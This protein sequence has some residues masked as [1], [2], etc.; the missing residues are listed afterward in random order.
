M[1]QCHVSG[2]IKLELHSLIKSNKH[3]S[4]HGV[5]IP[6]E[7][8]RNSVSNNEKVLFPRISSTVPLPSHATN[9]TAHHQQKEQPTRKLKLGKGSNTLYEVR[10]PLQSQENWKCI[11]SKHQYQ[12]LVSFN[13]L[14]LQQLYYTEDVAKLPQ[15]Y[16]D[17]HFLW[18]DI[19]LSKGKVKEDR[20]SY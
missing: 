16:R 14:A 12:F 9:C 6:L 3:Y 13:V 7:K 2:L 11:D 19:Q 5:Y 1:R 10:K 4:V 8:G 20:S 15:Y 17:N 18:N